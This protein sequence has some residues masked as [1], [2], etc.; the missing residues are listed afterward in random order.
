VQKRIQ[1]QPLL[2]LSIISVALFFWGCTKLDTTTLGAD[3][4]PEVDNVNTFADTLDIIT[5]QGAFE[6]TFKDT[7]KLSL[8]EEYAI[9]KVNDPLMGGTNA[10]LFLQIKPPYYPYVIGKAK[11]DSIVSA[12]SVVLCLSY[13]AFW[14]DSTQPVTLQVYEIS[15]DAH[16]EWDSVFTYRTINYEPLLNNAI[17]APKTIDIRNLKDYIKVG[18]TDSI[19]NQI[20]IKLSNAFRDSLFKRDTS[21]NKAF[22]ADSLFRFFNNGFA[23]IANSGNALMYVNLLEDKTRLELH[24]K[25]KYRSSVDSPYSATV[26]TAYNSFYFNSGLQGETVRRSSVANKILRSRNALPDGS[27]ELYLQT[28]PGT[29]A[30]LEIP[31]LSNL[32]NR[33]VHRAEIQIQ[34]I[35]DVINDKTYAESSYM[36]LDL[37]DSGVNKWKP[38]YFDLNPGSYYDSDFKTAG[39]P[40]FP[41]NGEV[42]IN[43]FG[44]YLRKKVDAGVTQ[45]YYNINITRY[46][47]QL[48]TKRTRNYKMRLFPA[49]SFTYPQ[50]SSVLIPYR[51]PIAYGRTRIGGGSNPNP[52]Y[53][54][55]LRIIYSKIK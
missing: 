32:S 13:K 22:S 4:I 44:G 23:V 45:A 52:A 48:L 12:D 29:F 37:V 8:T 49:H 5:T 34:Q 31:D 20:R 50:Y 27:Q 3:L 36:Y 11:Y 43:Y 10:K 41:S 19:N 47:Q 15:E 1:Q 18:K 30:N 24:Y 42:D 7:T 54:M 9:G 51:N 38:I 39:L 46:I 25:R 21:R 17:S 33:I 53:R 55:R 6:G 35:P 16:G 26:D 2:L 28:T 14:G 40:Y